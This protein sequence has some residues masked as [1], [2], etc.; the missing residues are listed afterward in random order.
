MTRT[1]FNHLL[2]PVP[3]RSAL[4][5]KLNALFSTKTPK[6]ICCL[7]ECSILNALNLEK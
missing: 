2:R 1:F 7:R 6:Y 3:A 4:F 5:E